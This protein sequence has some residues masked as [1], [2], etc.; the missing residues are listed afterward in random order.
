MVSGREQTAARRRYE[1]RE[2]ARRHDRPRPLPLLPRDAPVS[3]STHF[4][5]SFRGLVPTTS[6]TSQVDMSQRIL[7]GR[8]GAS[9]SQQLPSAI[10]LLLCVGH[11]SW[12]RSGSRR[13]LHRYLGIGFTLF[14]LPI[15]LTHHHGDH[16]S[17]TRHAVG[18]EARAAS[19]RS[20][21]FQLHISRRRTPCCFLQLPSRTAPGSEAAG[22]RR[23][24]RRMAQALGALLAL[25]LVRP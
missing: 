13:A 15:N 14:M 22:R 17:S 9:W 11:I 2:R 1:R 23:R 8:R 20:R 24:G 16:S 12:S 21:S 6:S 3:G 18:A 10:S 19:A 25:V 7:Q 5:I 4:I